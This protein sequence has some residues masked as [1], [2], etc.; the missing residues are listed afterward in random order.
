[1]A[2]KL[3]SAR[4]YILRRI[5]AGEFRGG[6]KLPSARE[7]AERTG[8]SFPIVQ[9]AFNTLI[10]TAFF[11]AASLGREPAFARTGRNGFSPGVFSRSG[12]SGTN[13]SA[14]KSGRRFR[15]CSPSITF[16]RVPAKSG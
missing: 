4:E 16:R 8:I 5:D 11:Q 14:R 9:M 15:N 2:D 13:S 3:Q 1:M 10:A 12:R 7:L 6:E